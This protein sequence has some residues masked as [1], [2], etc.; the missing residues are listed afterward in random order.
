MLTEEN[1]V[2]KSFSNAAVTYDFWAKPQKII[3][4][5]LVELLPTEREYK[6]VIDLGCGTGNVI[7]QLLTYYPNSE[8]IGIDIA[9][10]MIEHCMKRWKNTGEIKFFRDDI[11]SFKPELKYDLI[12]SSCAFQ[13]IGEFY[14]VIKNLMFSLKNDGCLAIAVPIEGS[15]FE[16]QESYRTLFGRSMPGLKYKPKEYYTGIAAKYDMD[17]CVT[18]VETVHGCFKGLDVLKY[19]KKIGA[20]FQYSKGYSPLRLKDI[21]R[22]LT[23]YKKTYGLHNGLLPVTH[24]VLYLIA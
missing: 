2:D 1:A 12:I 11:S 21:H 14:D 22:L 5:R 6:K 15:F 8:V 9:H 17:L 18:E 23:Y 24:K 10:G 4:Q 13:W 7:E 19:F 16:L 20:T 3:A